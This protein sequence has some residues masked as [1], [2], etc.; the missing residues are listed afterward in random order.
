M[1]SSLPPE[2]R[3]ELKKYSK[4]QLGYPALTTFFHCKPTSL[5]YFMIHSISLPY[6]KEKPIQHVKTPDFIFYFFILLFLPEYQQPLTTLLLTCFS[7]HSTDSYSEE[8]PTQVCKHVPVRPV[9]FSFLI[10]SPL[11]IQSNSS[12]YCHIR[13]PV[14]FHPMQVT[15]Q[16]SAFPL[17]SLSS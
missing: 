13:G 14:C 10:A 16:M 6:E 12:R 7:K 9:F 11:H 8:G 2:P 5:H 15:G 4:K 17:F 3:K 1:A